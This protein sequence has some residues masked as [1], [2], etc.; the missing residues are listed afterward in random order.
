MIC[1]PLCAVGTGTKSSNLQ[2]CACPSSAFIVQKTMPNGPESQRPLTEGVHMAQ[3]HKK[4]HKCSW[5]E[6]SYVV[7]IKPT[8]SDKNWVSLLLILSPTGP[9]LL[10]TCSLFYGFIYLFIWVFAGGFLFCFS[11]KAT[12]HHHPASNEEAQTPFWENLF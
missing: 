3:I 2:A 11:T 6:C 8:Y 12:H 4:V 1:N 7:E 10:N 5:Y 9:W